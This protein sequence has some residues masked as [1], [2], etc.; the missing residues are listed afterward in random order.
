MILYAIHFQLCEDVNIKRFT[1]KNPPDQLV[2]DLVM[3]ELVPLAR[4]PLGLVGMICCFYGGIWW[5]CG[6]PCLQRLYTLQCSFHLSLF[7][8]PWCCVL[9]WGHSLA[10][11]QHKGGSNKVMISHVHLGI[12]HL[13][14]T[15]FDVFKKS[16]NSVVMISQWLVVRTQAGLR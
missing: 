15:R 9:T 2:K 10:G 8:S 14:L 16:S 11:W 5:H 12:C 1:E 7:W 3:P 13:S 6:G 4:K